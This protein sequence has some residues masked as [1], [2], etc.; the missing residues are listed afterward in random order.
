M[1]KSVAVNIVCFI[2]SSKIHLQDSKTRYRVW[3][4]ASRSNFIVS[5]KQIF[6]FSGAL[7]K[8]LAIN[9]SP[10]IW[11]CRSMAQLAILSWSPTLYVELMDTIMF[12][13]SKFYSQSVFNLEKQF[14]TFVLKIL[15]NSIQF[16][17]LMRWGIQRLCI[18][19]LLVGL[20]PEQFTVLNPR[21]LLD[22]RP[23]T[24]MS[25]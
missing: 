18:Y 9:S 17:C 12:W 2:G 20:Y 24:K 1:I 10:L 8:K 15:S 16:P 3:D 22:E 19:T 21:F 25:Y 11:S 23:M 13:W 14:V 4:G 5:F 6:H 7:G